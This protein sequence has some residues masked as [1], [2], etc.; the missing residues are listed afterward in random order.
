MRESEGCLRTR[1]SPLHSPVSELASLAADGVTSPR[2][3]ACEQPP[4][5]QARRRALEQPRAPPR[6]ER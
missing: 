4:L 6:A 1:T 5:G 2:V 3:P